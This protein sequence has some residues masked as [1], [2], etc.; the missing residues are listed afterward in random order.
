[1]FSVQGQGYYLDQQN[2]FIITLSRVVLV[3]VVTYSDWS[4][5]GTFT[6]DF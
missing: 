6:A 2:L 4:S 5:E 3:S 1:M